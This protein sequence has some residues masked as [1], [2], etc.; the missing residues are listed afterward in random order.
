MVY[1]GELEWNPLLLIDHFGD[2]GKGRAARFLCAL[3]F[4]FATIGTNVSANSVS[5]A[6]DL[7]ALFP[8]WFNVRLPH[9]S[10]IFS[11]PDHPPAPTQRQIR[12]GSI[13][14]SLIGG[15]CMAPWEIL[16]NAQNFLS[17][18]AGYTS[19]LGPIVGILVADFWILRR[20]RIDVPSLYLGGEGRY[21]YTAGVNWRA[22]VTLLLT[23]TPTLPGLVKSINTK[24]VISQGL[25]NLYAVVRR[26]GLP[27]TL[28]RSATDICTCVHSPA[29][30]ALLLHLGRPRLHA[31]LACLQRRRIT[32]PRG[33]LR[34]SRGLSAEDEN[35]RRRR[36]EG[37]ACRRG[38]CVVREG[39]RGDLC[40]RPWRRR[41]IGTLAL[42]DLASPHLSFFLDIS[43]CL[44]CTSTSIVHSA[45]IPTPFVVQPP[46]PLL[47]RLA[48]ISISLAMS[49]CRCSAISRSQSLLSTACCRLLKDDCMT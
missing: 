14:V 27:S 46:S 25:Q 3:S 13:L 7:C 39:Q 32:R 5:A 23:V 49:F 1:G 48:L 47:A 8:R 37:Q 44:P 20:G 16:A 45:G 35:R 6:N 4:A 17:F 18:M 31:P 9:I 30:L 43:P 2:D 11:S 34:A 12:R 42:F 26:L 10:K 36:R 24:I 22:L 40:R 29:D 15:W 28:S 21:Y 38:G 41:P 33:D 19:F